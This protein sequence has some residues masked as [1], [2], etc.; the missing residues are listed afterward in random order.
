M[1]TTKTHR[2]ARIARGLSAA[3]LLGAPLASAEEPAAPAAPPA[4]A[5]SLVDADALEVAKK[6]LGFLRDQKRF[7]FTAESGYEVVQ[8]GGE[9]LEFG[10]VKH[11]T[12]ERPNRVRVESEERDGGQRL[13]VFDGKTLTIAAPDDHAY[14]QAALEKPHDIDAIVEVIRDRLDTPLPLA[15]L[16]KNDP[17][18]AVEDSLESAYIVDTEK[19][20][21][22]PCDHLAFRNPDTDVQLWF[23][24]GA[25]P[26][27]RRI[28]LTYRKLEDQPSYWA[29]LSEWSF[30]PKLTPETFIYVPPEGTE[31]IRFAV[32]PPAGTP[33]EGGAR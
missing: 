5:E 10:A 27:L 18:K 25:K 31:R 29:D 14:A 8:S 4:E 1:T 24:Q 3:L 7:S 9:R 11:Y 16:L 28:V 30:A 19:L 22:V 13:T 20:H 33:A 6:A 2:L 26:V 12:V 23:E 15:E 32:R 21:G 17:R